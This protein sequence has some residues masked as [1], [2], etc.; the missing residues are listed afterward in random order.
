LHAALRSVLGTH[1]QQKGSFLNEDTLRFDFQHFQKLSEEELAEIER[2][3]NQKIRENVALEESRNLPIE[4]AQKA[5]AM[6]LFG[7]KYGE[8]V[9]MITFDPGYS[10]ELCGGCHVQYTGQIGYF[11]ITAETAIA[12]GVRRIEAV[13]AKGAE[14]YVSTL[15]NE[16]ASIKNVL[17][18]KDLTKGIVALQEENK[19]LQKAIERMVQEQ[20]NG[21][22]EGLRSKFVDLNGVK[23]LAEILPIGDANAVKNLAVEL[24]RE[25]GNAVIA[26]GS[27]SA[28]GKPSLTIKISDNLVKEKGL[29]AGTI[30]RELA[31]KFLKGGGGGQPSFATA[32]GT[33]AT[34][35]K[36]A[37][38]GV[39]GYLG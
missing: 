8:T 24:E 33:D 26:F 23:F 20:A 30:V 28:D 35:L 22:R 14:Q 27:V 39:R 32:G 4:E 17:K 3:V 11:K 25:T 31:Q 16:L 38:A 6:M 10:R 13:T 19:Q 37:V 1:V 2:I 21:L 36:D 34:G 18:A 7:E 9:R 12:A 5:G 15:E 29:N